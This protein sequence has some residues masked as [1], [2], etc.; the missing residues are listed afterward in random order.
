MPTTITE[1]IQREAP[2]IEALRLGLIESG[3]DLADIP[4]QLPLQNVAQLSALERSAIEGSSPVGG[5][6]AYQQL[7]QGGRET[8]GTGLG[9]FDRA[10]GALSYAPGYL[11]ESVGALGRSE[12]RLA[13]STGQFGGAPG[14]AAQ[15][16]DPGTVSPYFNQ[17]EDAAVQQALTDI[18]RQGD[19]ARNQQNAAAVQA[20]AFGSARQGLQSAE[21]ARNILEQQGRT[22]AGMRQAGFQSAMQQAME[23]FE[24]QQRRAQAESQFGTQFG[25]QAFEDAQRRQQAAAQQ[26]QGIASL[27]GNLANTQQALAGQYGNVGQAQANLGVQQLNAAQ[28][29]QQQGLA[30]LSAQQVAGGLERQVNQAALNAEFQNA[31]RQ[32]FEPQTRLSWLSD[33]YKGAPSS[34]SAIGSQ[35]SPQAPTP[36]LFQQVASAGTGLIGA[37]AGAKQIGKLF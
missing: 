23:G 34:Q 1:T 15:A 13:G 9:T 17:F 11:D 21:L 26:Q 2:E 19:I 8:L 25:Q 37:A 20:D 29:A 31:Q 18:R 28:Q 14:Y 10:L 24:Q 16:F 6:G 33:I 5:I 12:Q 22:A 36:S 4:L 35:V 3:K 30:G 27:Y 7:A 32:L